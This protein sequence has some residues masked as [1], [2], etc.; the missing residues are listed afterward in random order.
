MPTYTPTESGTLKL[1]AG[2]L[3]VA[4]LGTV[5]GRV[6]V[7]RLSEKWFYLAVQVALLLVSL[8]LVINAV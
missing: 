4:A 6:L 8:K 3:P 7:K 2:L 1:S 5:L